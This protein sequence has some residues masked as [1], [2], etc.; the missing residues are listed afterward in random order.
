MIRRLF[1]LL[2]AAT[3]LFAGFV[4]TVHPQDAPT[5]AYM[6]GIR[7]RLVLEQAKAFSVAHE[8]AA[9]TRTIR[10]RLV[11]AYEDIGLDSTTA[12][13]IA[14]GYTFDR[15]TA[16]YIGL[17]FRIGPRAIVSMGITAL[18]RNDF[19]TAN[20]MLAAAYIVLHA[21]QDPAQ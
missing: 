9:T 8:R 21:H 7:D 6:Q 11:L 5:H 12:N 3:V 14:A 1:V 17:A 15:H 2:M 18:Q 20:R 19:D 13:L 10:A 4:G 16:P